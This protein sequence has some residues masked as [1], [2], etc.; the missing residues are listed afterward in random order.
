MHTANGKG[1]RPIILFDLS[2][3]LVCGLVGIEN[4][5]SELEQKSHEEISR[6]I[7]GGDLWELCRGRI[8]EREY[9]ERISFKGR[10]QHITF[11]QFAAL[12]R[13]LFC[14]SVPG[15]EDLISELSRQC[16]LYLLSDH[17]REWVAHIL[18]IHQHLKIF[19]KCYFSFDL[20]SVKCDGTPFA[21]VMN[22][23]GITSSELV[24]VDD[25]AHNIEI[26]SQYGIH[27]YLFRGKE[28]LQSDLRLWLGSNW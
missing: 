24:F 19:E 25:S 23:L 22:D 1:K 27:S 10:W 8:S 17:A 15:M 16:D 9:F 11:E 13:S 18:Q 6:V 14:G 7:T 2:E 28:R 26:A 3:V 20:G 5:L 4:I 21:Y 12:T